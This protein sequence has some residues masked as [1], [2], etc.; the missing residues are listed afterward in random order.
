MSE[1]ISAIP[2]PD[3]SKENPVSEHW[4]WTGDH[5]PAVPRALVEHMTND[6]AS[7]EPSTDV[8]PAAQVSA[9]RRARIAEEFSGRAIVVATGNFK[10]RANDTD[11]RFRAGTDFFYLTGCDEPDAVLV[12]APT[13]DGARS[14]LYIADRR[15]HRTHEFFTDGRYGELWVGARRGVAE[16][17]VYYDIDTAPLERLEADLE[18]MTS[19]IVSVR[20]FDAKVDA[21]LETNKDDDVLA[22][23]LSEDRLVKDDFEIAQLQLAVDYTVKGFEDVVRALPAAEGRGERVIEG[24]FHLRARVEGND[25]GYDTIAASGSNATVLHWMRNTGKVRKGDLL[26][27][28]AGVECHNLYTADVTRTIPI[29]GKYSAAQRRIYELVLGAQQAGIDA[30][31]PGATFKAP[32]EAAMKVLAQGLYDLGILKETPEAALR[33]E[34]QL[35]RRYTLH[36][37]SHMLGLDVHDCAN[38][39][40]EMYRD[41]VLEEGYVLTVEPGLYFQANDLTVPEEYRGIG[42]RI[43]DDILVTATGSRN[44]SA[45]LPRDPDEIEAWMARLWNGA[46]PNLGL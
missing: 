30:V 20:G 15:D 24:V 39:R 44:L 9:K 6:W 37:T 40:D 3:V 2:E 35:H 17:A 36:G 43:E 42:V 23:A 32:H 11:Y 26:L 22:T 18:A 7:V 31:K 33:P 38:A 45:A 5:R 28:D 8:H 25:T 46:S 14:T 27:L 16:A 19:E 21:F 10:V 13:S 41:G 4:I 1:N 12:I 29:S 34:R